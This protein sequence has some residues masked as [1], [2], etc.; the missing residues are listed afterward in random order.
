MD[1]PD[2]KLSFER[3]VVIEEDRFRVRAYCYDGET[4][5]RLIDT[6]EV[7][8]KQKIVPENSS[9]EWR[10]DGKALLTLKKENGPSF[11][12][13]LLQDAKKEVK[14][15]QVWWEMREKHIEELEE[16]MQDD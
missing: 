1:T 10:G 12:K 15:L 9:F 4:A 11:W 7:L 2:C 13:Y 14:E 6:Q 16:Y 8:L 3:Q 5:I